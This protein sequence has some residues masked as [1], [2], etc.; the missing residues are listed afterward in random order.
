MTY[1]D[2]INL[3]WIT[4]RN[5]KFSPNEAYLYFFLLNECNARDWENPFECPNK[6]IVLSIGISEHTLID[7]RNRLQSK[8]LIRFESGKRNEKSPKYYLDDCS[9]TFSKNCSKTFSKTFSK[10]CSKTFSKSCS[11]TFSKKVSKNEISSLFI[12]PLCTDGNDKKLD[13]NAC[14]FDKIPSKENEKIEKDEKKKVY[15]EVIEEKEKREKDFPIGNVVSENFESEF[16]SSKS[17]SSLN[18]KKDEEEEKEKDSAEKENLNSRARKI[19]ERYYF[20]MTEGE[21]YFTDK[22][23][24]NLNQILKKF[25][26]LVLKKG[27]EGTDEELLEAFDYLLHSI[28]DEWVLDHLS[29]SIINSKFNELTQ[30]ARNGKIKS[31]NAAGRSDGSEWGSEQN[32]SRAVAVGYALASAGEK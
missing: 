11:K 9:K 28:H 21:Y 20:D 19:F 15:K 31:P 8:G 23:A 29:V 30:Q 7:C 16:P 14:D 24:G 13:E 32:I 5:V 26:Y 3:F 6:R 2:Y 4:S 25:R 1:I 12:N 27:K 17:G 10:N 22:D 18:G